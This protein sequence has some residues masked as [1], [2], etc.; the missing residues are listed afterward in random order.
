MTRERW[1]SMLLVG[2]TSG[3]Y[4]P[5]VAD[6]RARADAVDCPYGPRSVR[7]REGAASAPVVEGDC[8]QTWRCCCGSG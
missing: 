3:V 1:G 4:G 7:S 2:Y 5:A 8:Q 6:A